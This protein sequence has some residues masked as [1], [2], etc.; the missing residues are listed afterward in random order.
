MIVLL[1]VAIQ[2]ALIVDNQPLTKERLFT[3]DEL[4]LYVNDELYLAILGS[5]NEKDSFE[6]YA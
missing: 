4:Q 1:A 3:S 5:N 2:R 6:S